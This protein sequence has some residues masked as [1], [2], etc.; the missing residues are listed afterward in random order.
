MKDKPWDKQLA[1][2]MLT[3]P[4]AVNYYKEVLHYTSG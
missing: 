1:W 3:R 2:W 4:D